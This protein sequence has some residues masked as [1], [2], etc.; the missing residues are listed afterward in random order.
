MSNAA[1]MSP[2]RYSQVVD[3]PICLPETE[4]RRASTIQ[5]SSFTLAAGQRAVLRCLNMNVLRVLTPGVEPDLINSAYGWV[6]VGVFAG[7]MAA[8]PFVVVAS[9][10][11]GLN[12]LYPNSEKIIASP[13]TY[14][15][16]LVNNTG[17]TYDKAVDL[18]VCVTGTIK[19]YR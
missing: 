1:Y 18:A 14:S 2:E 4:L 16:K 12:E 15:V 9:S 11:V 6:Y 8:S 5:I 7:Y 3:L 17:R 10:Q 13:G 19:F